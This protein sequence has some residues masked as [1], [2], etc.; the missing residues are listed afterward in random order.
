[1]KPL[2]Q[3]NMPANSTGYDGQPIAQTR[4][5]RP[6]SAPSPIARLQ[7][8]E[9]Q[10]ALLN[11]IVSA[12]PDLI[13]ALD[14]E[15]RFLEVFTDAEEMLYAPSETVSGRTIRE[16]FEQP[17]ADRLMRVG[18]TEPLQS[19]QART[20]TYALDVPAGRKHF[21]AH[22]MPMATMVNGKKTVVVAARDITERVL[23]ERRQRRDA[24]RMAF[25][26]ELSRLEQ[27]DERSVFEFLLDHTIE[28]TESAQGCFQRLDDDGNV[29][30]AFSR[31]PN[32]SMPANGAAPVWVE[33]LDKKRLMV[34]NHAVHPTALASSLERYACFPLMEGEIV[35]FVICVANKPDSYDETDVLQLELIAAHTQDFWDRRWVK[36][37]L[38]DSEARRAKA[39]QVSHLGSWEVDLVSGKTIWSE[40]FYRICGLEPHSVAPTQ[41]LGVQMIH[42]DDRERALAEV[43]R[44]VEQRDRYQIEKRICRPD[45]S[46]RHVASIGEV[47]VDEAQ[48]PIKLVGSFLDITERKEVELELEQHRQQLEAL[49]DQR[50]A[51][52]ERSRKAALS[53]MQDATEQRQRAESVLDDLR[54][55]KEA[56][57][58]AN[59]AKS[60]FLA[61]MSHEIRTPLN[62]ILGYSQL[63]RREPQLTRQQADFLEIIDRSGD[64]LLGLIN[65]VLE[66]SKIEAGRV[67][68]AQTPI[69]F[70]PF[71]KNIESLIRIRADAKGLGFEVKRQTAL[72][73]TIVADESKLRQLLLNV[74]GN[75]VKFTE[76]GEV[77]LGIGAELTADRLR[78][79]IFFEIRDSGPGIAPDDAERVFAPF[80][81]TGIGREQGGSG[82][83]LAISQRFARLM[84]G[85]LSVK[86][87]LGEGST[88][89]FQLD[90]KCLDRRDESRCPPQVVG[91]EQDSPLRVLVVDDRTD[92]REVLSKMLAAV[93]I[94]VRTARNGCEALERFGSYQPD[95]VL[96]DR[97]MP[98]MDGIEATRRIRDMKNRADTPIVIV[99]ASALS[100]QRQTA[101][102]A[103]ADGFIGK[104]VRESQ[105]FEEIGRLTGASFRFRERRAKSHGDD[106]DPLELPAELC[107]QLL[108]LIEAG[109]M[110]S[111]T[112]EL[113][114]LEAQYPDDV[115]RLSGLAKRYDYGALTRLLTQG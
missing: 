31:C 87:V 62:A 25:M 51:A 60:T 78:Q 13:F 97:R 7:T 37:A 86:S 27:M 77:S 15:G 106:E 64:H 88:F 90:V 71:I 69:A 114:A 91:L 70:A 26:L 50:T 111:L 10:S 38:R 66:M 76:Q 103:G 74:L 20:F 43:Q 14:E 98:V 35:R 18:I 105:L 22:S 94:E 3:D 2:R 110:S 58:A 81:Q 85:E 113:E 34:V 84:G 63:L 9:Q 16:I 49:V 68:L 80:E 96:M 92:N 79:R 48:N 59:R 21:E 53:L 12:I 83:G 29:V 75:A 19:G 11:A 82:L 45:G 44:A 107:K 8:S 47:I 17:L 108:E 23:A 102:E 42:P 36:E 65:D 54:A 95:L 28:L 61:N 41:E 67:E 30:S 55:A 5:S 112:S 72:P 109:D 46:V 104:P 32:A 73:P 99:S 56:A 4:G 57:D 100:E 52:L 39:E 33:C 93:G 101:L 24:E 6:P 40:E 1:M 89:R 115:R